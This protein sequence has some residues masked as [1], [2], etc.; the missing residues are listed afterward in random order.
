MP[1]TITTKTQ[2]AYERKLAELRRRP[3]RNLSLAT[4]LESTKSSVEYWGTKA[5]DPSNHPSH[6]EYCVGHLHVE[7][8]RL[9]ALIEVAIERNILTPDGDLI[10][11]F[12]ARS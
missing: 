3:V 4:A 11:V 1:T 12:T 9:L 2:R 8:G 6:T 5:A 7:Q 10:E